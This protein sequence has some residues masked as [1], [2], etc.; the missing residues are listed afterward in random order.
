M[1]WF[2][3]WPLRYTQS[4]L[5]VLLFVSTAAACFTLY[6][7]VW[8]PDCGRLCH[9]HRWAGTTSGLLV[10]TAFFQFGTTRWMTHIR[11]VYMDAKRFPFGP[12]SPITR[13]IIDNPDYPTASALRNFLFYDPSLAAMLGFWAGAFAIL[14]YWID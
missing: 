1:W 13:A 6:L 2:E 9:P 14:S 8:A 5:L 3:N 11:E 10:C 7:I 12:P 4:G